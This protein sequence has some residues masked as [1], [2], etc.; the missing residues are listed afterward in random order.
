VRTWRCEERL[1]AAAAPG[2]SR[3][4][5]SK[6]THPT[7][8]Q[9]PNTRYALPEARVRAAV[10]AA[11]DLVNLRGFGQR[12]THTLSGGQRQRV[13]IAGA[14]AERPRVLLLDELTTF[15]DAEDQ[16]GVLQAVR[17]IT[18]GGGDGGSSGSSGGGGGGGVTAVWVTHRFEELAYADS[19]SYM[20]SGRVVFTG[21][22][23]EAREMLK[24]MGASV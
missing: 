21:T 6:T 23:E 17:G 22:A 15:L 11:L 2:L 5:P 10:D 24:S 1:S 19:V 20:D 18:R 8:N 13:A 7:K 16:R 4:Q 9:K 3:A 12:A 14:L